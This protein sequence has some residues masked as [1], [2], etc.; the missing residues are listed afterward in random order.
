MG[1]ERTLSPRVR[2]DVWMMEGLHDDLMEWCRGHGWSKT[3]TIE[4]AVSAWL[5]QRALEVKHGLAETK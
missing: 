5:N 3:K 1:R 4:Y 2:I